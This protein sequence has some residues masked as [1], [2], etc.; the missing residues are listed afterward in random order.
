[1][2]GL[3]KQCVRTVRIRPNTS[4][5]APS[6][7]RRLGAHQQRYFVAAFPGGAAGERLPLPRRRGA[8][9]HT[10]GA[11]RE[12]NYTA[13]LSAAECASPPRRSS[14]RPAAVAS[15]RIRL[16]WPFDFT[17]FL[18]CCCSRTASWHKIDARS[19]R[20][21]VRQRSTHAGVVWRI[22]YGTLPRLLSFQPSRAAADGL[23][24][25]RRERDAPTRRRAN[26]ATLN[27]RT[28]ITSLRR[29]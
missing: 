21:L 24:G 14:Q 7:L 28:P 15:S 18:S 19:R 26:A 29:A 22:V 5:H 17:K 1:V 4:L 13:R 2:F 20:F 11:T 10:R 6:R 8:P 12:G 3:R 16:G 27:R 23:P 9:A 25:G